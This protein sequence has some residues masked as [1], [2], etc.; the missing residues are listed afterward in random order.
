MTPT[1]TR[2]L[3]AVDRM[4][5]LAVSLGKVIGPEAAAHVLIGAGVNALV[6][7]YGQR[8]GAEFLR[9]LAAEVEADAPGTVN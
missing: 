8:A 9:H 6:A 7:G 3:E 4:N 1:E 2:T 5:R